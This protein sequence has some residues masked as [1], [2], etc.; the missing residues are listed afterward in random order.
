VY[1]ASRNPNKKI[2][3]TSE[4]LNTSWASTKR[5]P[6]SSPSYYLLIGWISVVILG[7]SWEATGGKSA[8]N[9]VKTTGSARIE[10]ELYSRYP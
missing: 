5:Q 1:P 10:D 4:Q 7:F 6:G 9:P 3:T 2:M 8:K